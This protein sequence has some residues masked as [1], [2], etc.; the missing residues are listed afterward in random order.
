MSE[1][2]EASAPWPTFN[3]P[4]VAILRGLAPNDAD[5]I[6]DALV[7]A[8]FE[9]IEV[10]LNSPDPFRSIE[11]MAKR[12]GDKVLV[13]AGTVLTAGDANRLADA[14]GRLMVSPNIEDSVMEVCR[15]RQLVTMPGVF[16][17]TE[18]LKALRLGAS[19]LK[20]FPASALGPGGINAIRAV[21]PPDCVIGAVGGVGHVD[22]GRYLEAGV[23]AFGLGSSLFKVGLTADDVAKRAATTI[24][25][26]DEAVAALT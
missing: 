11:R 26:Y 12:F 19:G 17:A 4:L 3:R 6:G 22:F 7:E 9:A 21:L 18:A 15:A 13:G 8:G 20:F 16:T 23:S 24:S 14:G 10:P 2:F 25:A 1:Q 5:A